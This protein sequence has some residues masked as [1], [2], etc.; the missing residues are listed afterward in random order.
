MLKKITLTAL[1]IPF[2]LHLFQ[3]FF[4]H[5]DGN[6]AAKKFAHGFEKNYSQEVSDQDYSTLG[7]AVAQP[8][9]FLGQGKQMIA[10]ASEDNKYVLKFFNPMRPLKAKW[11][12]NSKYWKR[13][14]S[15]KWISREWLG[16]KAR[17]K[18]LFVRHK[19]AFELLKDETGLLFVH[20]SPKKQVCHLVSLKD[21]KGKEHF[22]S[23]TD[24][25][26]ILQEKAQL[27]ASYFETL[28]QENKVEQ[29]KE[30]IAAMETLFETRLKLGITDRIQTMENNYGFV[31][32]KPIQIDVGRIRQDPELNYEEEQERIIGN[33]RLWAKN[34]IQFA[35]D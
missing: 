30:A 1:T 9:R 34:S 4:L 3:L 13:Y 21:K 29:A 6:F 22:V 20:L 33:F 14:S 12:T 31:D 18:K 19:M 2:A 25:P 16:K 23:L 17:L 27:A 5:Y 32:G 8:Y 28:I 11:Y 15:L 35:F 26:F 24:T 10:F 7:T